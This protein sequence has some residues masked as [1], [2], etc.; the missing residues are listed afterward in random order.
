MQQQLDV[1]DHNLQPLRSHDM[2]RLIS[3]IRFRTPGI[4][5]VAGSHQAG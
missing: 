2:F 5:P 1:T 3:Q 4:E